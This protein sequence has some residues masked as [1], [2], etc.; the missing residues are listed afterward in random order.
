MSWQIKH[1]EKE[2]KCIAIYNTVVGY[3]FPLARKDRHQPANTAPNS[4]EFR[5]PV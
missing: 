5:C 3:G 1:L 2:A 4:K